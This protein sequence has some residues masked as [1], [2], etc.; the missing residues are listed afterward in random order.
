MASQERMRRDV[1]GGQGPGEALSSEKL[2][3]RSSAECLRGDGATFRLPKRIGENGCSER[4][5][6]Q[7][8]T[9]TTSILSLAKTCTLEAKGMRQSSGLGPG[10]GP[11]G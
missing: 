9:S 8:G 11:R 2:E 10:Q 6:G 7:T 4:V 1:L 5:L 3:A